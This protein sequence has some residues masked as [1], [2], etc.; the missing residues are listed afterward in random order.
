[1]THNDD[2]DHE[3]MV[4]D[5][6]WIK[7]YLVPA[8]MAVGFLGTWMTSYFA[9]LGNIRHD[10]SLMQTKNVEIETRL[11]NMRHDLSDMTD[12]FKNLDNNGSRQVLVLQ[13]M[14]KDLQD[15]VKENGRVSSE[16]N[17]RLI[18]HDDEMRQMGLPTIG[19]TGRNPPPH[20]H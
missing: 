5:K 11:D 10:I 2:E 18:N 20:H 1:M 13:Q 19:G 3:G 17:Q 16:V 15:Q 14:V 6:M 12:N 9:E 4:N 7:D 8:L